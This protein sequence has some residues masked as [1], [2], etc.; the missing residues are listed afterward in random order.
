MKVMGLTHLRVDVANPARP[1]R[2]IKLKLF[3]DS[4]AAYSVIPSKT[5]QRL[6]IRAHGERSFI[7][8]DG[9]EITRRI[10]DATFIIDGNRGASPVIFGEAGD[11]ALLGVV[12]LEAL[13]LTLDPIRRQ[14]RALP[15]ILGGLPRA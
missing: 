12:S 11:A 9:S 15:M 6:G 10:G 5:L 1:S 3:I 8:A 4:G 13:G 14:L 2:A 7:L